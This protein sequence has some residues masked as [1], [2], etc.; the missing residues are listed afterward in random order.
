MNGIVAEDAADDSDDDVNDVDNDDN[1]I[2][3]ASQCDKNSYLLNYIFENDKIIIKIYRKK[4]YRETETRPHFDRVSATAQ[5]PRHEIIHF[6]HV[7][8]CVCSVKR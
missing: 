5:V 8:V 2:E 3:R 6:V 4:N 7:C 1:S